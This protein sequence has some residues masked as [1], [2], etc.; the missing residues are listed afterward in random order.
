MS[1]TPLYDQLSTPDPAEIARINEVNLLVTR[2]FDEDDEYDGHHGTDRS[3]DSLA[4]ADEVSPEIA[5]K[6]RARIQAF[7]EGK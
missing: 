1:D 7:E 4:H 5:E 2:A 6:I 3:A